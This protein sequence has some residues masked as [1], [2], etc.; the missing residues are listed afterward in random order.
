MSDVI[1]PRKRERVHNYQPPEPIQTPP[2]F[3][4]PPRPMSFIR[5][6]FGVPGY[7]WPWNTLYLVIALCTWLVLT[8]DFATMK[9]IEPGWVAL[10]F[11]R[12]VAL[13]ATVEE[14]ES[15]PAWF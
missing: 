4:W 11:F 7:L 8:P 12:N 10:I 14:N 9:T 15:D 13:I 5:W 3:A 1:T 6:F 2:L